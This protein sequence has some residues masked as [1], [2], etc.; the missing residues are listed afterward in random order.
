MY[1]YHWATVC[2]LVCEYEEYEISIVT[3]HQTGTHPT[4]LI[5]LNIIELN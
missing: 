4:L 1:L 3:Q 5:A 2:F